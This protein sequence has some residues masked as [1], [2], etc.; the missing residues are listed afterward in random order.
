MLNEQ[1]AFVEKKKQTRLVNMFYLNR[2]LERGA[3]YITELG[4]LVT[5]LH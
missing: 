3:K 4:T 2:K 1:K 5:Y